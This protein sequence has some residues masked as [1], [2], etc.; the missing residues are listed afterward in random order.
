MSAKPVAFQ[1]L[2]LGLLLMGGQQ[3]LTSSLLHLMAQRGHGDLTTAHLM[4]LSN[5]DCG[6]TYASE[7]ARRMGVTRQAVYRTTRELQR[8]KILTLE[9][10]PTRKT[11]K[12][13]RMTAHGQRV[14][15]D[16]RACLD[17]IEAALQ[18]RIGERDLT[19]LAMVLSKEWGPPLGS[20]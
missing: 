9:T 8:L 1:R 14:V 3:W 5:L 16:A 4:F 13:I 20:D 17:E 18:L 15:G 7:V 6:D 2:Q 12:V 10:D 11:Q 19:E